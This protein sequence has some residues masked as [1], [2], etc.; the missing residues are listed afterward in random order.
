[1]AGT[2]LWLSYQTFLEM[3]VTTL[4]SEGSRS[5]TV[6]LSPFGVGRLTPY[7]PCTAGHPKDHQEGPD[8]LTLKALSQGAK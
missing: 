8:L 4:L 5:L 2:F 7:S 6:T 3:T 1:M